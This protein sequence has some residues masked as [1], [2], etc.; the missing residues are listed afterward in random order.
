MYFLHQVKCI[1]SNYEWY[2]KEVQKLRLIF[3]NIGYS[4]WC[5]DNTLKKFE[6]QPAAKNNS[7]KLEKDFLF[8]LG[9]PYFGNF[10]R[11]FVEKLSVLVKR[12]FNVNVNV[13]YPTFKI[14]SY[15][16]LKCS[17]RL[18][19]MSN[20]VY[21][22]NCSCNADL[23]YIGMTTHHLSVRVREHLHSKARSA[24]GSTYIIVVCA[25]KNQ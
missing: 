7:Q 10:S 3:N 18:S 14:G 2:L 17:T 15:F 19:L 12:K 24:A 1:C 11:Q 6:E 4:N 9:L 16:R 23:S 20:V 21:K 5:I 22:F 25:K 8:T 13:Y